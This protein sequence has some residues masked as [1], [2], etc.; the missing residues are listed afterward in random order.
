MY[1]HLRAKLEQHVSETGSI[2]SYVWGFGSISVPEILTA[3]DVEGI[4]ISTGRPDRKPHYT[5]PFCRTQVS[6]LPGKVCAFD[7]TAGMWQRPSK[8]FEE[9]ENVSDEQSRDI[10]AFF[11]Y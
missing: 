5:C 1:K 9:E 8:V 4:L 10:T 3:D 6:S 11:S 2:W 7:Q